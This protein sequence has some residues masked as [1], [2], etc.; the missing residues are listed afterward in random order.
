MSER[1]ACRRARKEGRESKNR[2]AAVRA[3][4]A[5]ERLEDDGLEEKEEVEV[6]KEGNCRVC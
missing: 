5:E 6:E 4:E 3:E 2:E 1:R